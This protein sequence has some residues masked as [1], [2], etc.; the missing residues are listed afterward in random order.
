[1]SD[2]EPRQFVA[3]DKHGEWVQGWY[4]EHH[5]AETDRHDAVIGYKT[6]PCI[7][8]DEP[9][10]RQGCYWHE[11]DPTTLRAVPKVGKLFKTNE[12]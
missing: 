2:N 1:M 9:L 11:I 5:C 4:V 8:N 6:V 7:F 12:L 3:K 10:H